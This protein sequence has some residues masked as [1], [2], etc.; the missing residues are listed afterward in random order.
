MT[1]AVVPIANIA[2]RIP[3][4]GRI[5]IGDKVA[6]GKGERPRAIDTFRF[7]SHDSEALG[8]ITEMYG[9]AV[10]PWSDPKAADGQFQV[11]TAASE[12]RVVLPP[13]PL[14]TTPIYELWGGG[15]CDRR[16]DGLTAAVLV[17]GPEGKE[18][19]DVPCICTAKGA[20]ECSVVTRLNV[21]LPEVRFAGVWR[22][23][24]KSWNAAQEMP[25]MVDLI[26][27][28]QVRG[29][30][31]ATLS[32]KHRRSV[33]G[34][35]TRKFLVPMLGTP[36][37]VEQIALGANQLGSALP[38]AAPLAEIGAAEDDDAPLATVT[39]IPIADDGIIDAEVIHEPEWQPPTAGSMRKLMATLGGIGVKGDGPR[40]AWASGHLDRSVDSFTSLS[41]I[42]VE[43]LIEVARGESVAR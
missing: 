39:A 43:R 3:E 42:D 21:I 10:I 19:A 15:G 16:C 2:R 35:Q 11:I 6:A 34:G 37:S 32:I 7:T 30:S 26:Q 13:D 33:A 5:R 18:P 12:I 20:M 41:D 38:S 40:H 36:A 17:A 8:Q 28:M 23:D 9:G 22:L 24:T 14:G 31:Y 4:A 25:G 29:L 1:R 27:S